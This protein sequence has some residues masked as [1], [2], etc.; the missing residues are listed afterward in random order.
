MKHSVDP[1]RLEILDHGT[2][3]CYNCDYLVHRLVS[4]AKK[5]IVGLRMQEQFYALARLRARLRWCCW[6]RSAAFTSSGG[7]NV[8]DATLHQFVNQKTIAWLC[9]GPIGAQEVRSLRPLTTW[10]WISQGVFGRGL[11]GTGIEGRNHTLLSDVVLERLCLLIQ[12]GFRFDH[13]ISDRGTK[14]TLFRLILEHVPQY[15]GRYSPVF[16]ATICKYLVL[17]SESPH[18]S[19]PYRYFLTGRGLSD[20]TGEIP[21][22]D[23]YSTTILHESVLARSHTAVV[24]VLLSN[25]KVNALNS[26]GH[27]S[28]QLAFSIWKHHEH[29]KDSLGRIVDPSQLLEEERIL[30]IL[31]QSELPELYPKRNVS[32]QTLPPG[33]ETFPVHKFIGFREK[34]TGSITFIPPTFSLFTDQRLALGFRKIRSMSQQ[35]YHLDLFRFLEPKNGSMKNVDQSFPRTFLH[36]DR[37]YQ[38]DID[39]TNGD[40]TSSVRPVAHERTPL[41]GETPTH[42]RT[43]LPNSHPRAKRLQQHFVIRKTLDLSRYLFEK[44]MKTSLYLLDRSSTHPHRSDMVENFCIIFIPLC[45]ASEFTASPYT[46]RLLLSLLSLIYPSFRIRLAVVALLGFHDDTEFCNDFGIFVSVILRY[47]L[48]S[49][50]SS[51]LHLYQI[52]S[53]FFLFEFL[54]LIHRFVQAFTLSRLPF[55]RFSFQP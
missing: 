21:A 6:S 41:L 15:P 51:T 30:R 40:S 29:G 26:Q 31:E 22:S 46:L 35:V 18:I 27:T 20:Q 12:H 10:E 37:W 36:S 33:W 45:I 43:P 55:N 23:D 25:F 1:D 34:H 11:Y 16:I 5:G 24:Q 14:K 28:A 44:F 4:L 19:A 50:L 2:T 54:F 32:V 7:F 48:V 8:L 39:I 47:V 49:S 3:Q 38:D 42:E 9:R 52:R 13:H 53:F 17:L